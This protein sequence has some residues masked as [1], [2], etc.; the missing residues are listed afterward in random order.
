MEQ[1]IILPPYQ[2][3]S[4]KF[5]ATFFERLGEWNS[6]KSENDMENVKQIVLVIRNNMYLLEVTRNPDIV[7]VLKKDLPLSIRKQIK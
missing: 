5:K 3:W 6:I 2:K 7:E 1:R 4:P